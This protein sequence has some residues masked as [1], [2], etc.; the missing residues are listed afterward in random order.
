VVGSNYIRRLRKWSLNLQRQS[1]NFASMTKPFRTVPIQNIS[2]VC[3]KTAVSLKL[4]LIVIGKRVILGILRFPTPNICRLK[5]KTKG[6]WLISLNLHDGIFPANETSKKVLFKRLYGFLY[7]PSFL[8]KLACTLLS[9]S[10]HGP[11]H[12]VHWRHPHV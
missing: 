5:S 10:T 6:E 7:G 11:P 4:Y 1:A 2:W 8:G 12:G 3:L 9:P